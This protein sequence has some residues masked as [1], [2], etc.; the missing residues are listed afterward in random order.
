MKNYLRITL[1]L[2]IVITMAFT[3]GCQQKNAKSADLAYVNWAE[4]VAYTHL[5]KV[6]LEE[7]MGYDVSITAADV[8]PAY[9]AVAQGSKDAFMETWLPVLHKDYVEKFKD[10]VVDLGMVFEGTQSGWVVPQYMGIDTISELNNPEVKKGL[11][12]KITGIDAGAGVMK[13]SEQLIEDYELDYELV[14]SSGPAMTAALKNA[15][16]D[17]E[18]IVVTGWKPH[19]M[20]G[21]WDLK[22]LKQ[23]KKVVWKSGNIHIM[24]RKKL[25]EEKPELAKFLSN[26]SFT[27]ADLSD[28][29]LKVKMSDKDV[30]TVAKEW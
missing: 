21:E 27:D 10:E 3:F 5:A 19:W 30:E 15:Y 14:P 26:F 4:G 16:K 11:K 24:G 17:E 25:Q 12:G 9:T 18:P 7:K 23:D 28:L 6:I 22:F 2:M 20:F 1:V 13:T 8:G 29:M